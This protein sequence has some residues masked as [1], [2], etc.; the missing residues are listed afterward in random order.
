MADVGTPQGTYPEIF[1]LISLFEVCQELGSRRRVPDQKL[2]GQGHPNERYPEI[3]ML[4][5]LWEVSQEG[6]GH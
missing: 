6:G 3:F 4:I 2:G 5:S 1:M